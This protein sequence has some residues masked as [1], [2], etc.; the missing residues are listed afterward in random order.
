MQG[1][2]DLT[3][4]RADLVAQIGDVKRRIISIL[5]RSFPEFAA[6]H[7]DVCGLTARPLL[8]TWTLPEQL[9]AV[10]TARLAA[11]LA[12]LSHDHFGAEKAQ[13]L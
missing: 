1:L 7:G 3:R 10:P 11:L 4:L 2:R 5:E 8:E 9:A 13:A 6:C 12:R